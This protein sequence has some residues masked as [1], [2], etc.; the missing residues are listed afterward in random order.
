[1]ICSLGASARARGYPA[2]KQLCARSCNEARGGRGSRACS[3]PAQAAAH[4][5]CQDARPAA[6]R[7]Q[8]VEQQEWGRT[9]RAWS[10][11]ISGDSL[12][13]LTRHSSSCRYGPPDS[14]C[15]AARGIEFGMQSGPRTCDQVSKRGGVTKSIGQWGRLEG[16]G[17]YC[18]RCSGNLVVLGSRFPAAG[19]KP[20]AAAG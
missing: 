14:V 10:S 5:A 6:P 13:Q 19:L 20:G 17:R 3:A 4:N 12:T 7:T 11:S 1:M 18:H 8:Q 15:R 2:A 16:G 9:T